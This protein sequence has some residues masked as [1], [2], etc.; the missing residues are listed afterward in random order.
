[1]GHNIDY[2]VYPENV[3]KD[4]VQSNWD[5]RVR[6]E[7]WQEGAVGLLQDEAEIFIEQID[8]H[9][10]D[11]LAVRFRSSS[12]PSAR[13]VSLLAKYNSEKQ[14][15]YE[16]NSKLYYANVKSEFIGCKK[17]GS[18][19][20]SKYLT[21]N[22]CPVCRTDMRPETIRKRLKGI[23]EKMEKIWAECQESQKKDA[24]KSDKLSWLVKTEYHT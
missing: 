8:R 12:K 9:D 14:K 4:K 20:A 24:Q 7:D 21:S 1:M 19:I 3:N 6:H 23:S 17:C 22:C 11:Q 13:T 10:Y 16:L 2:T 15:F 18:K 5:E